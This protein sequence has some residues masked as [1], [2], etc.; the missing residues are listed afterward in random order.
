MQ[1]GIIGLGRMGGNIARRLMRAGHQ[2]V[3]FDAKTE[4]RAALVKEGGVDARS[5]EEMVK[6]LTGQPRVVW[7]MLSAGAVTEETV[8]RVGALPAEAVGLVRSGGTLGYVLVAALTSRAT[9]RTPAA[10]KTPPGYRPTSR[11]SRL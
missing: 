8:E 10:Y 7:V 4:A 3:V 9:M 6:A 11:R 2:C 5:L 1:I